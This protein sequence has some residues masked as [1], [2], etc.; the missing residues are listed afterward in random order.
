MT[1]DRFAAAIVLFLCAFAAAAQERPPEPPSAPTVSETAE[2]GDAS[3]ALPESDRPLPRPEP[4]A[5]PKVKPIAADQTAKDEPAPATQ[6]MFGPPSPPLWWQQRE[7]DQEYAACKLSLALLGTTYSEE[8]MV[9][10]AE[11]RDCGIGRPLRV[12]AILPDLTLAGGAVM[13]C[14]TARALGF[15]ARDFLRP[16]AATLSGSPRLTGLQLGTTYDCRGRVG[17]GSGAPKLSEHARGNAI[18][19]MA[20]L[21]DG[22]VV[23]PVTPREDSGDRAEAFQRAAR[24]SACL[25]FTTVLG[26]GTN[27]AHADHLHLDMAQ[28]NRGWRLCQ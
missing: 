13:R 14:D 15:W 16:A 6:A 7:T 25:F 2:P 12:A 22:D 28:R 4:T 27:A 3:I 17:T 24:G 8:P 11:N 5:Q 23:L 19:I 21:L 1:R 20:F 10:D 18:D 9:T 26:P